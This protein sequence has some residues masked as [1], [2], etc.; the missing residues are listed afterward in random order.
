VPI[1]QISL[2]ALFLC[3]SRNSSL[4]SDQPLL[5][6][7]TSS[8][9]LAEA[10]LSSLRVGGPSVRQMTESWSCL[11]DQKQG[12][13]HF[14]PAE[15]ALRGTLLRGACSGALCFVCVQLDRTIHAAR[16]RQA[17]VLF[18]AW[19]VN[20]SHV[21]TFRARLAWHQ[22]SQRAGGHIKLSPQAEETG[23]GEGSSAPVAH[24][25]MDPISVALWRPLVAA[26]A[27]L[28]RTCS[29]RSSNEK[30]MQ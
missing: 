16:G 20:A 11:L 1:G 6:R 13:H 14:P 27:H 7:T 4:S 23:H 9:D 26:S 15:D 21:A 25:S 18:W 8:W 12:P 5:M 24:A 2:S 19:R 29:S 10:Q 3:A 22:A 30:G 28:C 17:R